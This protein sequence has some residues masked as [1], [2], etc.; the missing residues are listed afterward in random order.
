MIEMSTAGEAVSGDEYCVPSPRRRPPW[1]RRRRSGRE[2][3]HEPHLG[4]SGF[5]GALLKAAVALEQFQGKCE[6]VFLGKA[7]SAFPWEL[8]QNKELERFA[9]SVKR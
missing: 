5:A 9:V 3:Q 6:T 7:H 1:K 4:H 2:R 8:L